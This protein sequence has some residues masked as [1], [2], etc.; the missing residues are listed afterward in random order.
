MTDPRGC[1]ARDWPRHLY[2]FSQVNTDKAIEAALN[3]FNEARS[4][5]KVQGRTSSILSYS[6]SRGHECF[7]A[8][9]LGIQCRRHIA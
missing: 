5:V 4:D 6:K 1:R 7:V 2:L 8:P 9:A 3:I